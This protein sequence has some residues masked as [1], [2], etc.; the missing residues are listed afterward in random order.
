MYHLNNPI[1]KHCTALNKTLLLRSPVVPR[2]CLIH[3]VALSGY[4]NKGNIKTVH[5]RVHIFMG[6]TLVKS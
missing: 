5:E 4:Q 3:E 1:T 2:C 6:L